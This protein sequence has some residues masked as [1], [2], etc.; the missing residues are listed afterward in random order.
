MNDTRYSVRIGND[1]SKIIESIAKRE[2][3][4][5]SL[6]VRFCITA[7]LKLS[8]KNIPKI[9]LSPELAFISESIQKGKKV[10]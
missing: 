5:K 1:D 8:K 10:D 4:D 9:L 2:D 6:V 3:V 7:T